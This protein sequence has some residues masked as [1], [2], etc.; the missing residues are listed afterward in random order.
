MKIDD[1]GVGDKFVA[2]GEFGAWEII[3]KRNNTSKRS[4]TIGVRCI[5]GDVGVEA[6]AEGGTECYLIER[7]KDAKIVVVNERSDETILEIDSPSGDVIKFM[8]SAETISL[9]VEQET[10]IVHV[11]EYRYKVEENIFYIMV[12]IERSEEE[13]EKTNRNNRDFGIEQDRRDT[14]LGVESRRSSRKKNIG[15]SGDGLEQGKTVGSIGG[16]G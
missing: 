10:Q 12:M 6:M 16:K 4:S 15:K 3:S 13:H 1:L 7:K 9:N 5:F 11:V 8:T 14:D 2:N